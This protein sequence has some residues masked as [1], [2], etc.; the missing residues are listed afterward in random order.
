MACTWSQLCR[1]GGLSIFTVAL[2]S[3][4]GGSDGAGKCY[5]PTPAVCASLGVPRSLPQPVP[6]DVNPAGLYKGLTSTGRSFAGLVLDD[7]SFYSIY[8]QVNNPSIVAGGGR[9]TVKT[10]ET[11]FSI[12]NAVDFNF[13]GL[14]THI[15]SLTGTVDER[16]S[17][18][19]SINY[20]DLGQNIT[21]SANYSSDY[22]LTPSISTIVGKY[23]G[24]SESV[25]SSD[26][27]TFDINAS[28]D[29]TGTGN[30]GCT[31][32]GTIKPHASGN[33]YDVTI[34]FGASP[35]QYPGATITGASYFDR[36]SNIAYA[37]ASTPTGSANFITTATKQ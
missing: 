28:G 7:G 6:A 19:G 3:C 30:S 32:S 12:T 35:C 8:S 9:G 31:F 24:A 14:G 25:S 20:P 13:E 10:S 16:K 36:T 17:I 21:F 22:E 11:S 37:V 23:V 15:V 27:V 2:A 29:I 4:G 33:A 34:T 26:A 18:Q 5:S 1:A